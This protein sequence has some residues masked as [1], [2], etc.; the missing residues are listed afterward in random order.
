[1]TFGSF[2]DSA[3]AWYPYSGDRDA[4]R[5]VGTMLDY[6]LDA[7]HHARPLELAEG[8]V[9]HRLRKSARLRTMPVR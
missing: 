7:R 6:V 9:S 1:M 2:V 5:T 3:M 4:I 8:P